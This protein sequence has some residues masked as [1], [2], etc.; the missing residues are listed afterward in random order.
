MNL[1]TAITIL[2]EKKLVGPS[3]GCPILYIKDEDNPDQLQALKTE[4]FFRYLVKNNIFRNVESYC[5]T[6]FYLSWFYIDNGRELTNS[7]MKSLQDIYS[8]DKLKT[9]ENIHN[10]L[11]WT[12][13]REGLKYIWDASFPNEEFTMEFFGSLTNDIDQIY[14]IYNKVKEKFLD[15]LDV[16]T[17]I[18]AVNS[19]LQKRD[20]WNLTSENIN[21]VINYLTTI[22]TDKNYGSL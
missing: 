2:N 12:L 22:L 7:D 10:S 19:K 9:D 14:N 6:S 20:K 5:N 4:E 1:T 8:L 17:F 18:Q 11:V 16:S 3:N 13:I 15:K 21:Y